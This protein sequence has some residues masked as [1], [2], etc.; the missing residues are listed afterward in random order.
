MSRHAA[1]LAALLLASAPT[2]GW[3]AQP[4]DASAVARRVDEEIDARLAEA[5][6]P[7]SPP[8]D[9]AEFLRRIYLDLT[10]ELPGPNTAAEFLDS[11]DP[12]KRRKLTDELLD[13]SAH[14]ARFA[15]YWAE[16]FIKRNDANQKRDTTA[17]R[18]WLAEQFH[19]NIG[20]DQIVRELLTASGDSPATLFLLTNAEKDISP[21]RTT[22]TIGA[23]FLG[24]Q[25]QC[26]ECHRHPVVRAW[27]RED[28]WGVAAFFSRTKLDKDKTKTGKGIVD[29]A[30]S[31]RVFVPR[32]DPKKPPPPPGP[33]LPPGVLEIPS[34]TDPMKMVGQAKSR[35]LEGD[36]AELPEEGSFRAPLATWVTSPQNRWFAAAA[37]NRMWAYFFARGF[38]NPLDNMMPENK[39]SH[40][41]AMEALRAEFV[42]SGFDQKHL[43]RC[44]CNTK[45]YQRTSR[46][47]PAN[48]NDQA[49]F[50]HMAV[51]AIRGPVLLALLE[52]VL[53]K[54]PPEPA[55]RGG[56]NAPRLKTTAVLLDTAGYDES[57]DEYTAG[58]PQALRLLNTVL[59]ERTAAR[60]VVLARGADPRE[61]TIEHLY[62][63]TLSRRPRPDELGEV[64]AFLDKQRDPA[65]GYAGL[66]QA[67]LLA[68]EF[69][70]NH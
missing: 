30:E 50:S 36:E 28:F 25:L 44:I 7:A 45:A 59:P 4:R 53:G 1:A 43:I 46:S 51:K 32:P 16:L 41:A 15:A 33:H 68:P 63:I 42:A 29:V 18:K 65:K 20:W 56:K 26:A 66:L 3:A 57:P 54:G 12:D 40:P 24:T 35:Y 13:R 52:Q 62:L 37:V 17:F 64:C 22:G 14:G 6:I 67:L 39:A 47:L 27:K 5:K 38:V 48:D 2:A 23:L 21:S 70:S 58:V 69:V 11:A 19:R 9:D 49:L 10:G 31:P 60:A 8:A 61:K 55:P 34:A